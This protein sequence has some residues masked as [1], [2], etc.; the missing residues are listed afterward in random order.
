MDLFRSKNLSPMLIAQMQDPFDDPGWIYE[1]KLDGCRC[2]AYLDWDGVVLRNKRNMELLPRFPELNLINRQIKKKC[3]LDG[4]LVV[5]AGGVPDF[6]ELQKRTTLTNRAKIELEAERLP[7]SFVA[8]DCLQYGEKELLEVPLLKRKQYLTETVKE[9]ER[10]AISRFIQEKGTALFGMTVDKELEG[11]VAKKASSL[12]YPGKRTRDWIKFKRMADREFI[13]CGYETG[14]MVSLVLG[15][16]RAGKL[17]YAGTVTMGVRREILSL[18]EKGSCPFEHEIKE[19][20]EVVWCRP[21]RVCTVEYMP[22]T[23]D[24]LRQP[25]F[26][27]IRDDVNVEQ[28]QG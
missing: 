9:E 3:V 23:L 1:L 10:I 28:V 25:V 21:E 12:Y 14:R 20:R 17:E 26:K 2:I 18:L 7:V 15:E 6:Y 19:S 5:M 13:I 8:Y 16:Y 4:E 27:G 24:A 22:N 11:V